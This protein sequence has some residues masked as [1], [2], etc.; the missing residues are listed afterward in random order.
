VR[1][2]RCTTPT[3]NG[4]YGE[5]LHAGKKAFLRELTAER[6]GSTR[7]EIKA[8]LSKRRVKPASLRRKAPFYLAGTE[9]E[10]SLR[11][12]LRQLFIPLHIANPSTPG[13]RA[14]MPHFSL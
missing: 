1:H 2:T 11:H 12:R 4:G 3:Q 8:E 13:V 9:R 7:A 5:P 14:K 6:M 10:L